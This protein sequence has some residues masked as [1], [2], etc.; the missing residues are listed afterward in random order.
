[1]TMPA[2]QPAHAA[3]LFSPHVEAKAMEALNVVI[4][5]HGSD[6]QPFRFDQLTQ[7][8]GCLTHLVDCLF[9]AAGE[10][11]DF[12]GTDS[13]DGNEYTH[14]IKVAELAIVIGRQ[15]GKPRSA[16]IDLA[17][18]AALMNIGNLALR[19]SI[20]EEPRHLL[21]GEWEQHEH[22]HPEQ[23]VAL[24]TGSGLADAVLLTV[25]QHHERWDGSGYPSGLH[26]EEISRPA[27]ILGVADTFVSL[28]SIRPYR[29]AVPFDDAL[30]RVSEES[31]R[32]FDP[33]VVAAFEEVVARYTGIVRMHDARMSRAL[34]AA[35]SANETY[36]P[37]R[38]ARERPGEDRPFVNPARQREHEDDPSTHDRH[39]SPIRA[40]RVAPAPDPARVPLRSAAPPAEPVSN[41]APILTVRSATP[42]GQAAAA[43][44]PVSRRRAR[45]RRAHRRRSLFSAEFYVD[46]AVRGAWP[47]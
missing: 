27:R 14:P 25:G 9:P 3:P 5:V 41:A 31:G 4:V 10:V 38:P 29:T 22:T 42:A 40:R 11:A 7:L 8:H 1:M 23:G 45:V 18:A 34:D 19:G 26:E 17:M 30:R 13:L 24:L 47:A 46:A 35:A 32:L 15:L 44:A 43:S 16:L 36:V 21:E 33:A 12:A 20:L 2:S 6:R 28:R 39:T 37:P